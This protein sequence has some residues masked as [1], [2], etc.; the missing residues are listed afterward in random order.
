MKGKELT[1][2]LPQEDLTV[3][4]PQEELDKIL[5]MAQAITT[6]VK[7]GKV[8]IDQKTGVQLRSLGN[9]RVLI[10]NYNEINYDEQ[11]NSVQINGFDYRSLVKEVIRL[12]SF[13]LLRFNI[14]TAAVK[15]FGSQAEASKKLGVTRATVCNALKRRSK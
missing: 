7:D 10:V 6:V 8:T 14:Y 9:N 4:L 5:K 11:H 15:I 1:V 13:G 12:G 2:Q 3:Q